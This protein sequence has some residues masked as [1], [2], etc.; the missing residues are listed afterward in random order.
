[1]ICDFESNANITETALR[2]K[3]CD[4]NSDKDKCKSESSSP[5]IE[6]YNR[7]NV[8]ER[9][10]NYN[11]EDIK[12]HGTVKSSKIKITELNI[13]CSLDCNKNNNQRRKE[14]TKNEN[15]KNVHENLNNN[16]ED[17]RTSR[18]YVENK[19]HSDQ[20]YRR[21]KNI[22][23][24]SAGTENLDKLN[25]GQ[26]APNC[27]K[28]IPDGEHV[29]AARIQQRDKQEHEDKNNRRNGGGNTIKGSVGGESYKDNEGV[30]T[31]EDCVICVNREINKG[32]ENMERDN[33]RSKDIPGKTFEENKGTTL[34]EVCSDA[35]DKHK[36]END[37]NLSK[38]HEDIQSTADATNTATENK[39]SQGAGGN[40]AVGGEV[41]FNQKGIGKQQESIK[42]K[43]VAENH[44]KAGDAVERSWDTDVA[45]GTRSTQEKT[46]QNV[47]AENKDI[48]TD[49]ATRDST[50]SRND[51]GSKIGKNQTQ[52]LDDVG[53]SS[54]D[55]NDSLQKIGGVGQEKLTDNLNNDHIQTGRDIQDSKSDSEGLTEEIDTKD[56][57]VED[58]VDERR[59]EGDADGGSDPLEDD[60]VEDDPL[61]D[62]GIC[63]YKSK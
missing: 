37:T 11:V 42:K 15:S 23:S 19:D 12:E 32:D 57:P 47:T 17:G 40:A 38:A 18:A 60:P 26:A 46:E 35:A 6:N 31:Y 10:D 34:S 59:G 44:M 29:N 63:Y 5:D 25:M 43:Y 41:D 56:K 55:D 8:D 1:M 49:S 2:N 24:F 13:Q 61:S 45:I 21:D 28:N 36:K 27:K 22:D 14:E 54:D 52:G 3:N 48:L 4:E 9:R 33:I 62:S 7:S 20:T 39:E 30:E 16:A 58:N 51:A 50:D 53:T